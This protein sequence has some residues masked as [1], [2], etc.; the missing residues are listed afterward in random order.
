M[1]LGFIVPSRVHAPA[2][3]SSFLSS[4]LG[5]GCSIWAKAAAESRTAARMT[6][7]DFMSVLL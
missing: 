5:F 4:G 3:T 2:K 7:T 6:W 1:E